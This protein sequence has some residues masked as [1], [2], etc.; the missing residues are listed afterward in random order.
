MNW[1]KMGYRTSPYTDE[2]LRDFNH[3]KRIIVAMNELTK[4]TLPWKRGL[5]S[6]LSDSDLR[7]I[8]S[9]AAYLLNLQRRPSFEKPPARPPE[10]DPKL[11]DME[12]AGV[13]ERP[14]FKFPPDFKFD[15]IDAFKRDRRDGNRDRKRRSAFVPDP[16]G[17]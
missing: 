5:A 16:A 10:D 1:R 15:G 11:P 7:K 9:D 12:A 8:I 17:P 14:P 6:K 13:F 2:E 3:E 4:R